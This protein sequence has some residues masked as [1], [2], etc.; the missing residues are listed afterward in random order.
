MRLLFCALSLGKFTEPGFNEHEDPLGLCYVAEAARRAGHKVCLLQQVDEPDDE[1]LAHIVSGRSEVLAFTSVTAM[2]PRIVSLVRAAKS[3]LRDLVT[4]IGGPH[5][6]ADPQAC[7]QVFDY[8]VVGEGEETFVRLLAALEASRRPACRGLCYRDDGEIVFTGYPDRLRNLDG[9]LPLREGLPLQ[10]Y[11]P[12]GSPPVP[13]GTAG[14]AAM[15]TSRGCDSA[16]PFCCNPSIWKDGAT[17]RQCAVFRTPAD[18]LR[19]VRYLRDGLGVNY[20]AFEDTDLLA[21]PL[22]SMDELLAMLAAEWKRVK[23]FGLA[24]PDRILPRWPATAGELRE[25]RNR[26]AAL[27]ESGCHLLCLGVESGDTQHRARMG[28]GFTNEWLE[29]VFELLLEAR[30]MSNAFLILGYPGES[31][32]TLQST[33]SLVMRLKATRVRAGFFYPF[34]NLSCLRHEGIEWIAPAMAAPQYATTQTPTVRCGVSAQDLLAFR[35][36]LIDDFYDSEEY[37]ARL[38]VIA[39]WTPFWAET[40]AG[41]RR[42][43]TMEGYVLGRPSV[44]TAR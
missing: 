20:I 35:R 15:I 38:S 31:E 10:K 17:D 26:L 9:R 27:Q 43:L 7:A 21:R 37:D 16:C 8:V 2:W 1:V 19:E 34:G 36:Q 14:F 32:K 42:Q 11:D 12:R 3:Q 25:A 6:C 41:W 22:D 28:R 40:I 5:A 44:V 13:A 23:W 4:V 39:R 18:V 33:Y 30:I 24:R 29:A